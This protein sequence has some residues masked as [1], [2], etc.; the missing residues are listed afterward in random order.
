M[1][2]MIRLKTDISETRALASLLKHAHGE[3]ILATI[4][5]LEQSPSRAQED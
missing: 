1:I 2:E 5:L 3:P 4:A